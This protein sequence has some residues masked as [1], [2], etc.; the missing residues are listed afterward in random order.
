MKIK[1]I[2]F[3]AHLTVGVLASVIVLILA[4]SGIILAFEHQIIHAFAKNETI[5]APM[6]GSLKSIDELAYIARTRSSGAMVVM[7]NIQN[8][9]NAPIIAHPI[10]GK[11]LPE[12]TLN[13]YTG[14]NIETTSASAKAFFE[15][16]VGLHRWL[17]FEGDSRAIGRQITG[18]ANLFFMFLVATGIYL[19]LPRAWKWTFLRAKL[20]FVRNPPPGK[21]RD[22]NW[23]HVVSFWALVPLF[24]I[25]LSAIVISYPWA[26]AILYRAF[27][28]EAPKQGGPAFIGELRKDAALSITSN[29][30]VN[31]ATL[32]EAFE[33]AKKTDVDWKNIM[34]FIHPKS[35][36]PIVRLI[37]NSSNAVLP[38]NMI[39]VVFDREDK[40]ITKIQ[41]YDDLSAAEK[42]RMWI[43]FVHTGEQYGLLGSTVAALSSLA[44]AFLVYTG[45]ALAYRR[46]MAHL[47]K[48]RLRQKVSA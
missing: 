26:N 19:W 35:D 41:K 4:V 36:V 28:A 31:F 20:L 46:L 16:I 12:L 34:I 43:R 18:A 47:Q 33:L 3:W 2:I 11:D 25:I 38:K 13:P 42:A 29:D 22:Y 24:V 8:K 30:V 14:E 27:G 23:H 39:T 15:T 10:G 7:L 48:R 37:V 44:S 40:K 45:L 6:G 17:A 32:Q 5:A 21:A 9:E 1:P